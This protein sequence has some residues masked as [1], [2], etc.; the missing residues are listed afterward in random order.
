M[1]VTGSLLFFWSTTYSIPKLISTVDFADARS[2]WRRT[3]LSCWQWVYSISW[4]NRALT[5]SSG[6]NVW[7]RW[8]GHD[9]EMK[10]LRGRTG[11]GPDKTCELDFQHW[12]GLWPWH[13]ELCLS[14]W[15][16]SIT[17]PRG[18]VK[19]GGLNSTPTGYLFL[20]KCAQTHFSWPTSFS[21]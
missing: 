4:R 3:R 20:L 1:K 14:C 13:S 19:L 17:Q 12:V 5:E 18:P 11:L 8:L 9:E 7:R 6:L 16:L 2:A 10:Q 15:A 21:R